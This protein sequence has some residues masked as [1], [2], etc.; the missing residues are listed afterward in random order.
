MSIL[1]NYLAEPVALLLGGKPVLGHFLV[2]VSL[3]V[4]SAY[5]REGGAQRSDFLF[6]VAAFIQEILVVHRHTAALSE[7]VIKIKDSFSTRRLQ[8]T[9]TLAL[10]VLEELLVLSTP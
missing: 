8:E 6:S 5:G 1:S 7:T 3:L 4:D 10:R 9:R 2:N